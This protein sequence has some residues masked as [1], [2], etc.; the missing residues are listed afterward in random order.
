ML[1]KISL[2]C[3]SRIQKNDQKQ[4]FTPKPSSLHLFLKTCTRGF[5]TEAVVFFSSAR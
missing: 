3:V 2:Q 1:N 5:I 4:E